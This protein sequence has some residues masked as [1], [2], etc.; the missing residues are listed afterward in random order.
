MSFSPIRAY[1]TTINDVHLLNGRLS[2]E[3]GG[4]WRFALI[5]GTLD[6]DEG[7]RPPSWLTGLHFKSEASPVTTSYWDYLN[8]RTASIN[9]SKTNKN[10]NPSLVVTL[11]GSTVGSFLTHVLSNQE[12]SLGIWFFE[13]SPKISASFAR[14][15]AKM[16]AGDLSYELRMQ[17]KAS[18][19]DA[20]DHRAML[21]ANQAL[22][23]VLQSSG[24]KIYPPFAPILSPE[25]WLDHYGTE[26]LA[27]F[28]EAKKRFDPN[29]V[30]TPGAG[31]F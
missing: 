16:P 6:A 20:P 11:P 15:L 9:H 29:N 27:R 24:G 8:R 4:R 2:Q 7:S 14:P 5:A 22:L 30:L 31:I 17:R 28:T 10:P 23:P 19:V 26:T 18:T 25:Q 21:A 3:Q 13:V 12:A 1:L